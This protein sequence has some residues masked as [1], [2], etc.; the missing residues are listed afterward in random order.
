MTVITTGRNRV[1]TEDPEPDDQFVRV[2]WFGPSQD[3]RTRKQFHGP[4]MPIRD[5]EAAVRWAVGIADQMVHPLY[6]VPMTGAAGLRTE[7]GGA[8]VASLDDQERGELRRHCVGVLTRVMRDC[9]DEAVRADAYD[10]L[11]R[12]GVVSR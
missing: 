6:V 11:T 12:W 4:L 1:V 8:M 9:E 2:T 5:Y 3:G 7:A 10:L